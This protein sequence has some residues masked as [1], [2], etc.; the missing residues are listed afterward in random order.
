MKKNYIVEN[1]EK[2]FLGGL[3]SGV[4]WKLDG[5]QVTINF[6]TETK[7]AAGVLTFNL[8]LPE[9]QVGIYYTDSRY[10]KHHLKRIIILIFILAL[11]MSL[12]MV[13]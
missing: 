9:G 2:Y 1:I 6:S 12:L 13:S 4:V 10:P 5:N 7:D 8:P 11:M 3:V